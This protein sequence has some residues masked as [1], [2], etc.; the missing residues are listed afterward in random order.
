MK[1]GYDINFD[2][3]DVSYLNYSLEQGGTGGPDDL[4]EKFWEIQKLNERK[5]LKDTEQSKEVENTK[6]KRI[7][8]SKNMNLQKYLVTSLEMF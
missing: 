4:K 2:E 5:L 3:N 8:Y 6:L 1:G 7:L